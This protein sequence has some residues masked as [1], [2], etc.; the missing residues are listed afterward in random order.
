MWGVLA[1]VHGGLSGPLGRSGLCSW[2]GMN[3]LDEGMACI[4]LDTVWTYRGG[5][6]VF[7]WSLSW[8]GLICVHGKAEH[9]Y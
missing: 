3:T 5:L 6:P 2:E 1:F 4:H 9:T 7:T 8:E